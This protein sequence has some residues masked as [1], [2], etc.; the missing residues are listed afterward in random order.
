MSIKKVAN[1]PVCN[2]PIPFWIHLFYSDIAGLM[3]TK[4]DSLIGH[5]LTVKLIKYSLLAV[6]V[7]SLSYREQNIIWWFFF[8]MSLVLSL[9]VQ[10]YSPFK[11]IFKGK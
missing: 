10:L 11:I 7:I 9:Y 4:C 2:A 3:C 5:T 6:V 8:V 1:C